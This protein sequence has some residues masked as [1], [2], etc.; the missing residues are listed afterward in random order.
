MKNFKLCKNCNQISE[1]KF[2]KNI[3]RYVCLNCS[4]IGNNSNSNVFLSLVMMVLSLDVMI[5][6]LLKFFSVL[7]VESNY[8]KLRQKI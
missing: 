1:F 8:L 2:I 6:I 4:N 7:F 3:L 5:L